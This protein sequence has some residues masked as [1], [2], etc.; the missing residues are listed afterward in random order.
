MFINAILWQETKGHKNRRT[1]SN[2]EM[3][4]KTLRTKLVK[5][6]VETSNKE[7]TF[8]SIEQGWYLLSIRPS[9]QSNI[10]KFK[11]EEFQK[12]IF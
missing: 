8:Y 1:F 10:L 9:Y 2:H 11:N 3:G 12:T 4:A 7:Q 5:P 6:Y